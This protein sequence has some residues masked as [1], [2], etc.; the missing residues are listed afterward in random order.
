MEEAIFPCF[1]E[2]IIMKKLLYTVLL[3]SVFS[4]QAMDNT[5][6]EYLTNFSK[7]Y[8]NQLGFSDMYYSDNGDVLSQSKDVQPKMNVQEPKKS[9]FN[10]FT[11]KKVYPAGIIIKDLLKKDDLYVPEIQNYSLVKSRDL[12]REK[13]DLY[14]SEIQNYPLVKSRDRRLLD[15]SRIGDISLIGDVSSASISD[16]P[17]KATSSTTNTLAAKHKIVVNKFKKYAKK[18]IQKNNALVKYSKA[19]ELEDNTSLHINKIELAKLLRK[20]LRNQNRKVGQEGMRKMLQI[21]TENMEQQH[22]QHKQKKLALPAP[23]QQLQPIIH[24]VSRPQQLSASVVRPALNDCA[25]HIKTAYINPGRAQLNVAIPSHRFIFSQQI[26]DQQSN[27]NFEENEDFGL[28]LLFGADEP[29]V[30]PQPVDSIIVPTPLLIRPNF[31]A[32]NKGRLI[33]AGALAVIGSSAGFAWYRSFGQAKQ[34]KILNA[35]KKAALD[36]KEIILN[37]ADLTYLTK[38]KQNVLRDKINLFN[39]QYKN[40]VKNLHQKIHRRAIVK[41]VQRQLLTTI[42]SCIA[43][44]KQK[45]VC[46]FVL[47]SASADKV[48]ALCAHAKNYIANLFNKAQ[49]A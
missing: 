25:K 33:T 1:K 28:H 49:T 16:N 12:S 42:D 24:N 43:Q 21:M 46:N 17:I 31:F 48:G 22:V 11:T 41:N 6:K 14:V 39:A 35:T 36:G 8:P 20:Q 10:L 44:I 30:E 23:Q 7:H 19:K 2:V 34:I 27:N 13:D 45:P 37:S 26:T 32:R 5:Q 9:N 47:L 15:D 4:I 3:V 38:Q 40:R 18:A 29:V